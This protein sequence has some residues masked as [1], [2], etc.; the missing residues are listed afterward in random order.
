[1][2][3]DKPMDNA[4]GALVVHR[5]AASSGAHPPQPAQPQGAL[6][7]LEREMSGEK[8]LETSLETMAKKIQ[9]A[10]DKDLYVC[11]DRMNPH[12]A[13]YWLQ[14]FVNYVETA[15]WKQ[16]EEPVIAVLFVRCVV[17]RL[18]GTNCFDELGH[19]TA[20][21]QRL[22]KKAPY[23]VQDTTV[24]LVALASEGSLE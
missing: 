2:H 16:G 11:T 10:F 5:S 6:R 1:M 8:D 13:Q 24:A 9:E 22:Q 3:L 14:E 20:L 12:S 23:I 17:K 15:D 4:D 7:V 21:L 18:I 19:L